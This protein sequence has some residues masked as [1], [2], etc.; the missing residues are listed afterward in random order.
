MPPRNKGKTPQKEASSSEEDEIVLLSPTTSSKRYVK[1]TVAKL[2]ATK[3]KKSS[4]SSEVEEEEFTFKPTKVVTLVP[5]KSY[6][7]QSPIIPVGKNITKTIMTPKEKQEPVIIKPKS[8]L[9]VKKLS[10]LESKEKQEPVIIKPK[11]SFNMKK[12]VKQ[13]ELF[14]D[15]LEPKIL[16]KLE[17]NNLPE[18]IVNNIF[19]FAGSK[20]ELMFITATKERTDKFIASHHMDFSN[21][22]ITLDDFKKLDIRYPN[23]IYTGLNFSFGYSQKI[24]LSHLNRNGKN[25]LLKKLKIESKFAYIDLLDFVSFSNLESLDITG[26]V[27]NMKELPKFT[28]LKKLSIKQ[29][30]I[31]K[32]K[33][34][35]VFNPKIFANMPSL[36]ELSLDH[37]TAAENAA[38][39]QATI[40]KI[41]NLNLTE[42]SDMKTIH[43]I[44]LNDF[45]IANTPAF[46]RC[47]TLVELILKECTIT[48]L[49]ILI[50]D[51]QLTTLTLQNM[52]QIS[53]EGIQT[54]KELTTL[55]L[56][57]IQIPTQNDLIVLAK[58]LELTTVRIKQN[59]TY[60]VKSISL[61]FIPYLPKLTTLDLT[62]SITSLQPLEKCP[63]LTNLKIKSYNQ[64]LPLELK[65]PLIKGEY[66]GLTSLDISL[67]PLDIEDIKLIAAHTNL[68]SLSLLFPVGNNINNLHSLASLHNL[69]TLSLNNQ[70][71]DYS[72]LFGMIKLEKFKSLYI[73]G[74]LRTI[75]NVNNA[76]VSLEITIGVELKTLDGI[77]RLTKLQYLGLHNLV[78]R[79][80]EITDI[81][82]IF[83]LKNLETLSLIGFTNLVK[84][85]INSV[86]PNF[87]TMNISNSPLIALK[88]MRYCPVLS[89]MTLISIQIEDIT[90]ISDCVNLEQLTLIHC[91]KLIDISAISKCQKLTQIKIS[92]CDLVADISP[93]VN[94]KLLENISLWGLNSVKEVAPLNTLP[95]L[96]LVDTRECKGIIDFSAFVEGLSPS[97]EFYSLKTKEK[98][99]KLTM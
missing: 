84:F 8:S 22:E 68:D 73:K 25:L 49:E 66:T 48:N 89:V 47:P 92:N 37:G 3:E 39:D 51:Y 7:V 85:N 81:D 62:M 54:Q 46:P 4:S 75:F 91:D 72:F 13:K 15:I 57:N 55:I 74:D 99:T 63:V 6:T 50:S 5:P 53:M 18:A 27:K 29:I 60:E 43:K 88:G 21:V 20:A 44:T 17:L 14:V 11:S 83:R 41:S 38:M 80:T 79:N 78:L 58:C 40:S 12:L 56:D 59:D 96:K 10:T 2:T 94:C 30:Y 90:D 71:Q 64:D 36:E 45:T 24:D 42:F 98:V 9:D 82:P 97:V 34:L 95:H 76:L 65:L 16:K 31:Y 26:F 93:L 70:L 86:M 1:P 69:R 67:I 23:M 28:K 33:S 19:Q 52:F 61:D 87:R 32:H 35:E 77:E